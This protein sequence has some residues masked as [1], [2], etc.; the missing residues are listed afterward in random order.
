MTQ[1][2]L[3][4]CSIERVYVSQPPTERLSTVSA[5]GDVAKYQPKI[6]TE[7]TEIKSAVTLQKPSCF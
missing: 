1:V 2:C 3:C 5:G 7:I 4:V 6:G